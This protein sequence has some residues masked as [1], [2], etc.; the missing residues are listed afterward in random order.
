[1]IIGFFCNKLKKYVSFEQCYRCRY[2]DENCISKHFIEILIPNFKQDW[3]YI[4][5]STELS[6][7]RKAILERIVHSYIEY[8]KIKKLIDGIAYHKL[9][10]DKD[11]DKEIID[12]ESTIRMSVDKYE[13]HGR[14]DG[15]N[16]KTKTLYDWKFTGSLKY[17]PYEKH[18]YQIGLYSYILE[19]NDIK[20]KNAELRYIS[21]YNLNEVDIS[22]DKEELDELKD[23]SIEKLFIFI[24]ALN[25]AEQ[26][27]LVDGIKSEE[28][29]WCPFK[30]VCDAGNDLNKIVDII[31]KSRKL[32]LIKDED[33]ILE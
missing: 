3:N 16:R 13:I 28:C 22:V 8:D 18:L 1:M 29:K 20:L 2:R 5:P 11:K 27:Y 4:Y 21:F 23:A 31:N 15:Y 24:D 33:I 10:E 17:V 25:K 19:N 6:C 32:N 7:P 12:V 26:G 30:F 9:M 14:I